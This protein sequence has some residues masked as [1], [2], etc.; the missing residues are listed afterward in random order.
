MGQLHGEDRETPVRWQ[1]RAVGPLAERVA[2]IVSSNLTTYGDHVRLLEDVEHEA[3]ILETGYRQRQVIELIQNGADALL[4]SSG[5]RIEVLVT[6]DCL[7]VANE[8]EPLDEHGLEALMYFSLSAKKGKEI[9]RLGVGFKSV[10]EVT[11]RPFILSTTISLSFDEERTRSFLDAS[12]G[13]VHERVPVMRIAEVVDPLSVA[14]EFPEV[15]PYL[16]WASTIVVLPLDRHEVDW[17]HESIDPSI[18]PKEF[19]LFSPHVG[20]VSF[21]DDVA[22][23]AWTLGLRHVDGDMVVSEDDESPS[24]WRLATSTVQLSEAARHDGGSR[25]ERDE[26][27][28]AWA[29]PLDDG[30]TREVWAFFPVAGVGT[31]LPG[32]L[33]S[34]WKLSEDRSN[35]VQGA[36]NE[37][38]IER[39]AEL[40]VR[41]IPERASE[42]VPGQALT[43]L[44][45]AATRQ[46]NSTT[47]GGWFADTLQRSIWALARRSPIV[48]SVSGTWQHGTQ[49]R[50]WPRWINKP[51]TN[52][53]RDLWIEAVTDPEAWVHRSVM[54]DMR[55]PRAFE[56][57]VRDA[58]VA[59]WL[60]AVLDDERPIESSRTA[61]EIVKR[62]R[63]TGDA[64]ADHEEVLLTRIVWTEGGAWT[65]VGACR[66]DDAAP[67]DTVPARGLRVLVRELHRAAGISSDVG[68]RT[69]L[70][71]AEKSCRDAGLAE[72]DAAAFWDAVHTVGPKRAGR[73]LTDSDLTKVP[74][75]TAAGDYLVATKVLAEGPILSAGEDPSICVDPAFHDLDDPILE[76]IG[77]TATPVWSQP[78]FGWGGRDHW[79]MRLNEPIWRQ[80]QSDQK[81]GTPQDGFARARPVDGP[82]E[83]PSHLLLLRDMSLSAKQRFCALLITHDGWAGGWQ[84]R[85]AT[86]AKYLSLEISSPAATAIQTWGVLETSLGPLSTSQVVGPSLRRWDRFVPVVELADVEAEAI[87]IP[88]MER[89]ALERSW[90]DA[91]RL[92]ATEAETG[93]NKDAVA[94]F[95]FAASHDLLPPTDTQLPPLTDR[96][97]ELREL[98]DAGQRV[99]FCS[100]ELLAGWPAGWDFEGVERPPAEAGGEIDITDLATWFPSL[101]EVTSSDHVVWECDR[102]TV[103]GRPVEFGRR[104]DTFVIRRDAD[105]GAA[106]RWAALELAPQLD[107]TRRDDLVTHA[108]SEATRAL[109]GAVNEAADDSTR[110]ALLLGTDGLAH[111]GRELIPWST[112]VDGSTADT[113]L[114][115]YG[116]AALKEVSHLL[117]AGLGTPRQWAGGSRTVDFVRE[118]GFAESFAGRRRSERPDTELVLGPVV[119]GE[120]HPFQQEIAEQVRTILEENGR[121]VVDLPTGAGKTRVAIESLLDHADRQGS[122][123]TVLWLAEREELCEQA[124]TQWA[125]LWRGRGLLDRELTIQR[126][127]G[128]RW[129]DEVESDRDTVVV[130]SRQQLMHRL[131]DARLG[132]MATCRI[133]VIDEAHH[134][135]AS[136]YTRILRWRS[137]ANDVPFATIGLS[138]T[139]FR[140]SVDRTAHL[141]RLFDR[142]LVTGQLMGDSWKKRIKWLQK[143]EYLS[144]VNRLDLGRGTIQP[145]DQ[146]AGYLLSQSNLTTGIDMMNERLADDVERNLQIIHTIDTEMDPNWSVVVFAGSVMHAQLLAH[147]LSESGIPSRPVWGELSKWARRDAI[148]QFRAKRIRVITNFNVLSEGFDA[149]KTRAV[150]IARLVQ[151]DG[152]F[153]QMLGRGMRGPENGGTKR[154]LLVTMGERLPQRFDQD[155]SLDIDRHEYLWSTK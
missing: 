29:L 33:N 74:V 127:W 86:Q 59:E 152:L 149:P 10:L 22:G 50:F 148:E 47:G 13:R 132:W 56:L 122:L 114:T 134:S 69:L 68:E 151:S 15:H 111:A 36:F 105:R 16:E 109:V 11:T 43:L 63:S 83:F 119:A 120:L 41:T 144:K 141:S 88:L 62:I 7:I 100:T 139:P 32:I 124:V 61:L 92:A 85:H 115:L 107:A 94:F 28:L 129:P 97:D 58:P 3:K 6:E 48:P 57:G 37:F 26:V 49:L 66:F 102:V 79:Y 104:G 71:L 38:L 89:A 98:R 136:S 131:D 135:T 64:A 138:A 93:E 137:E 45:A 21:R 5:G 108:L 30:Q 25:F 81:I 145:T 147:M 27:D 154:C 73:L 123:G 1:R 18:F 118:L 77:V 60:E 44:P 54:T 103:A 113:L 142:S 46:L 55:V 42:E 96:L 17:V 70:E 34:A 19:L 153:L 126:F 146:E 12:L 65:S 20:S 4:G 31:P 117:P 78:D 80:L 95:S 87:G 143:K 130:C 121:G 125:Q 67:E 90:T 99:W 140:S 53:I 110:L 24:R 112:N 14:A 39:A 84:I 75:R 9:G 133:V 51:G 155:G 128:G 52:E 150:V 35:V 82:A 116:P 106:L 2:E 91:F 76:R 23:T 8:G 72:A 40:V 101:A